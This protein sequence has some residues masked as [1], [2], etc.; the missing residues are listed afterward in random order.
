MTAP[1]S[2]MP[3][4]S[5]MR[6]TGFADEAAPGLQGQIRATRALG[7]DCI[8]VRK[9]HGVHLHDLD[10]A[11]FHATADRIEAEG[12]TVNCLGSTVANWA[13]AVTDPFERTLETLA[14]AIPRMQR[15]RVPMIRIMSYAVRKDTADQM[16]AERFRRLR[17]IVAR[18]SD[19]GITPVHENCMNYGGMGW[20]HTL[21]MLENVPGLRLVF[22][23]GNPVFTPD[24]RLPP[25][26]PR[27]SS[28]EFYRNVR[29]HVVHIHVKDAIWDEETKSV[30]HT[31][32]GEGRGDVRRILS[33]L[34]SRGYGG[35]LSIE[36]HLGAARR[37]NSPSG[38]SDDQ[39]KHHNY[40]EYGKRLMSLVKALQTPTGKQ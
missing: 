19:A 7:W 14:R 29:E 17:E 25:P 15:L 2:C 5:T 35:R 16:E 27:Q 13:S 39:Q 38:L 10:E 23:T 30:T 4:E 9:I 1:V 3:P 32:P 22:D 36:P 21:R 18:L 26:H 37:E 31:F 24:Y 28:W 20:T 6:Y 34:L 8:E 33:D 40:V 11:A 12:I